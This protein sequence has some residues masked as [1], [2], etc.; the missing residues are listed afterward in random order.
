M[1]IKNGG[2]EFDTKPLTWYN[3]TLHWASKTFSDQDETDV[4]KIVVVAADS[5]VGVADVLHW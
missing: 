4:E 3:I 2:R 5:V 1:A